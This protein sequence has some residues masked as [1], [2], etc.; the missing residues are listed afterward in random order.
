MPRF[1]LFGDAMNTASRMESTGEVDLIQISEKTADLLRLGRHSSHFVIQERGMIEV[2]GKGQQRTFWL[3]SATEENIVA[4]KTAIQ[5]MKRKCGDILRRAGAQVE[6][7]PTPDAPLSSMRGDNNMSVSITQTRR[8]GFVGSMRTY[9]PTKALNVGLFYTSSVIKNIVIRKLENDGH[10]V[11][12]LKLG[13]GA[14][15]FPAELAKLPPLNVNMSAKI[16]IKSWKKQSFSFIG[17]IKET[18]EDDSDD[19]IPSPRYDAIIIDKLFG[20]NEVKQVGETKKK[21]LPVHTHTHTHTHHT[22]HTTHHTSHITHTHHT[23]HTSHTHTHT[24]THTQTH[25]HTHTNTHTHH[26]HTSHIFSIDCRRP[27]Q[28]W[29]FRACGV[30]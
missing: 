18:Q 7:L 13:T 15:S 10:N 25:T 6:E 2:K 19:K 5:S 22:S 11:S 8:T 30:P 26:T 24:H 14:I 20:P 17:K 27:T 23:S 1:C 12:H 16:G 4:N 3:Q 28:G 29:L 9:L 21:Q